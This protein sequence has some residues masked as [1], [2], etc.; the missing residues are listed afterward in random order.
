MGLI[1]KVLEIIRLRQFTMPYKDLLEAKTTIF[2]QTT[3]TIGYKDLE[4]N[5]VGH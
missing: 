5:S 2:L 4:E 3:A 1:K